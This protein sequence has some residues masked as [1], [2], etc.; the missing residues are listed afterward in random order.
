MDRVL[1]KGLGDLLCQRLRTANRELANRWLADLATVL[2]VNANE[3]FPSQDL[4]DHVPALIDEIADCLSSE[5]S[6]SLVAN[7]LVFS[8]AREMGELRFSQQA[9]VHQIVREYRILSEVLGAFVREQ[10]EGLTP[11]VSAIELVAVMNQVHAA[12]LVLLQATLDTF[13]G[14]YV[15][16]LEEQTERLDGFNR[17]VT[18]ELRQPLSS[19]LHA[20]QILRM[21]AGV[22]Q[23]QRAHFLDVAERNVKRLSQLLAMLSTLAL[24][25]PETDNPQLQLV[26]VSKIIDD[27]MEQ[28]R[29][30]ADARGV[31][32]VNA[33]EPVN[34]TIDFSRLELVLVNLISNGIKYRDP[35][36]ANNAVVEVTRTNDAGGIQLHI[37]DNGLGIPASQ[38]SRVFRR[39]FRAHSSRDAELGNVGIGLGLAIAAESVKALKGTLTFQS[40]EGRGT[41]FTLALPN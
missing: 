12:V 33:V 13:V 36:K 6:E 5:S 20:V 7:T 37:R 35:A 10:V 8:K 40:E 21:P 25:E 9:S 27:V 15:G 39:F 34:L 4:L 23:D 19:V 14:R 30:S 3:I 26:D 31:S 17:M 29:E 32:L 38:Q 11:S 1:S 41:V 28:L 18:H 2:Q 16:R 22:G 24:T